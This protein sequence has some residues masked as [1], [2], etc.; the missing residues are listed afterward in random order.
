MVNKNSLIL[1]TLLNLLIIGILKEK[2]A[3]TDY[4]RMS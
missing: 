3:V 2:D 4:T 1:K